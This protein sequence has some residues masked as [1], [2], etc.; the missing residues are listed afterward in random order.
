VE[1]AST[2]D[3]NKLSRGEYVAMFGAILLAIGVFLPWYGVDS[4]LG[5]FDGT[6]GRGTYS[7]W[8]AHGI[9]RILLLLAAIAP[10][11]LAWI[12]IRDHALSWPRG[13]LTMVISLIAVVLIGYVGII[14]RPGEPSGAISLRWG[15]FVALVGSILMFVGSVSRQQESERP[16]KPPGVL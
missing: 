12:V 15:W 13:E 3:T 11:V 2:L 5:L 10:F 4:A 14:D 6:R 16:R 9:I 8:E 1:A 7:G